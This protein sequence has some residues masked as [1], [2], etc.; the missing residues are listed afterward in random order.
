MA[1]LSSV[2]TTTAFQYNRVSA[3][4]YFSN[5]Q[6][7]FSSQ[8]SDLF[9]QF[10]KKPQG[11]ASLAQVQKAVLPDG[12]MVAVKVQH[13]KVQHQ[14][15]KDIVVMEVITDGADLPMPDF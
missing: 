4:F 1:F 15:S 7:K 3:S 14:S 8:L 5:L 12:R 10:E 11:A 2:K 6:I 9:I 13:P